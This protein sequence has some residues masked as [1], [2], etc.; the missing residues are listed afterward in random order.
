[1][2][3][4]FLR[5]LLPILYL[6]AG[7]GEQERPAASIASGGAIMKLG[8][9][10]Q[11]IGR[12]QRS[13]GGSPYFDTLRIDST[14]HGDSLEWFHFEELSGTRAPRPDWLEGEWAALGTD[15]LHTTRLQ[16][17]PDS[18]A[19]LLRRFAN[20]AATGDTMVDF[21]TFQELS[22]E[23]APVERLREIGVVTAIEEDVEV[24][25]GRY[26]AFRV[27]LTR[28]SDR[29]GGAPLHGVMYDRLW[30][31]PGPGLVRAESHVDSAHV[32]QVWELVGVK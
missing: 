32:D 4:R 27:D 10:M 13:S 17:H 7:C 19:P 3:I 5:L 18:G 9:G 1:M 21:G 30:F 15:G 29:G 14:F 12:V 26:T 24:P 25:A 28:S 22:I 2:A 8:A 6:L 11:W 16:S 31:A 23:G 20:P